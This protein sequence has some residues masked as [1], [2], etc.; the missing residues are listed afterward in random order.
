M[1]SKQMNGYKTKYRS[2]TKTKYCQ[3]E[4]CSN[5]ILKINKFTQN[6]KSN[7]QSFQKHIIP[8]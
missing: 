2:E 7:F 1:E 4:N 6:L 5:R 3:H 8:I